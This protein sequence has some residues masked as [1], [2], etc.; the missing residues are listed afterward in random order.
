MVVSSS[1]LNDFIICVGFLCAFVWI[2]L[3]DYGKSILIIVISSDSQYA[4]RLRWSDSWV[5]NV[6]KEMII[7]QTEP[8]DFFV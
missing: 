8:Y 2:V 1:F 3:I 5:M 4:N 7:R 6:E